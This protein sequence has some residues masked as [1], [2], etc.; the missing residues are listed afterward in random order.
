[1]RRPALALL[2][3]LGLLL[4]AGCSG[5]ADEGEE[6]PAPGTAAELTAVFRVAGDEQVEESYRLECGPPG[7]DSDEAGAACERLATDPDSLLPKPTEPLCELPDGVT[8][9]ELSGSVAG[10]EIEREYGPCSRWEERAVL[11]WIAIFGFQYPPL[12]R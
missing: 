1:M 6:A 2:L 3:L 12:D 11:D 5:E 10:E 8:Y 7:G 4:A 9:L